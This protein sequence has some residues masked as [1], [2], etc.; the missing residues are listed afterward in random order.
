MRVQGED[1]TRL[2]VGITEKTAGRPREDFHLARFAAY[3]TAMNGDAMG[4]LHL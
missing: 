1:V 2:F 4:G 3:L